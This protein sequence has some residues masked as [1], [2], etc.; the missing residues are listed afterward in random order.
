ME[1]EN[2]DL[3]IKITIYENLMPGKC[4]FQSAAEIFNI[5]RYLFVFVTQNFV[6]A[7]LEVFLASIATFEILTSEEVKKGRLIPVKTARSCDLPM[8]SP[9]Q[10]LKYY[11][12]LEAKKKQQ[13]P[14]LY[15]IKCFT[16]VITDGRQ[17]YLKK[18][19]N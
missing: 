10:P 4:L 18:I 3:K 17:K 5:C 16:E 1:S 19:V 14:D 9:F 6:E 2:P 12:Y 7:D 15:F 8:L 11:N 13:G